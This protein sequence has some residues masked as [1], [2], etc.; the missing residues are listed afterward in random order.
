LTSS[1]LTGGR[2]RYTGKTKAKKRK[3]ALVEYQAGSDDGTLV[4]KNAWEV[5][6][7]E[8]KKHQRGKGGGKRRPEPG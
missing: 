8:G 2:R 3:V 5:G 1:E 4:K 6:T 7:G